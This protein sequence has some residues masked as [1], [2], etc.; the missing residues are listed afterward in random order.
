MT[1][2]AASAHKL[3]AVLVSALAELAAN[4]RVDISKVRFITDSI[5]LLE[6]EA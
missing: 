3:A 2:L 4:A 1:L 5:W 6:I